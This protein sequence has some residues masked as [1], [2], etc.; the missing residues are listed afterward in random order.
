MIVRS[1]PRT[2]LKEFCLDGPENNQQVNEAGL[3]VDGMLTIFQLEQGVFF[4][5]S[6]RM[7]NLDATGTTRFGGISERKI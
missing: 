7:K 1:L 2:F 6:I 5:G 4:R 3:V